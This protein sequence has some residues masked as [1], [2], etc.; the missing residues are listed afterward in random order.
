[1]LVVCSDSSIALSKG[2]SANEVSTDDL[3]PILSFCLCLHLHTYSPQQAN[4]VSAV[5]PTPVM[6]QKLYEVRCILRS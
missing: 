6:I 2:S 4:K 5:D 3:V 1:M